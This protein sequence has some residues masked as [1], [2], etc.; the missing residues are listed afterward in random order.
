M[1]RTR[2]GST[3]NLSIESSH[4]SAGGVHGKAKPPSITA[5]YGV[6]SDPA[7]LR[8]GLCAWKSAAGHGLEEVAGGLDHDRPEITRGSTFWTSPEVATSNAPWPPNASMVRA[9]AYAHE[10]HCVTR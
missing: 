10:A 1:P 2:S 5:W 4:V 6:V 7:H 3:L 9:R 8:T